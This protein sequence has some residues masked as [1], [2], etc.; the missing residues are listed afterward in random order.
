MVAHI[1]TCTD[2]HVG[3]GFLWEGMT[4]GVLT[5]ILLYTM[6]NVCYVKVSLASEYV[7]PDEHAQPTYERITS[8]F[9]PKK[10]HTYLNLSRIWSAALIGWHGNKF[11]CTFN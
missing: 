4:H 2:V 6:D 8:A 5:V 1:C 7:H 9:W 11:K 3:G 10:F